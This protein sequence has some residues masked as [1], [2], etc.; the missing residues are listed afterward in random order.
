M[1]LATAELPFHGTSTAAVL[2]SILRDTPEPPVRVNSEL[3]SELGRIIGKSL[4]KDRDLRYQNAAELRGDLKRLKRDTDSN[5]PVK[6]AGT[7]SLRQVAGQGGR[8]RLYF[9]LG[10]ASVILGFAMAAF[11]FIRPLPPVRVLGT[12]QLTDDRRPKL[13]PFLTDGS[14]VYFNTGNA[15]DLQTQQVSARGGESIPFPIPLKHAR[16]LDISRDGS[17]LLVGSYEQVSKATSLTLWIA[18]VIGGSPRRLGDIVAEDAGLSADDQQVVYVKEKERE[19]DIARNDGTG[20][21]KL[22]T[23]PGIPSFPRWSPDGKR[24]RFT[25]TSDTSRGIWE[26]SADGSYL[27]ALLPDWREAQCCGNWTQD[28]KYFVFEATS[29]GVETVWA[30]REKVGFFRTSRHEPM[31]LTPGPMNTISPVPSPDGNRLF[32]DGYQPRSELVRYDSKSKVFAPF[33]RGA[34]IQGLDFSRDGK[35]VTYVSYPESTLWRSAVDGEQRVQLTASPMQVGLP[36]WSPDGKRIAFMA[37]Y[38]GTEWRISM[39]SADGG[40]PEQLTTGEKATGYD[41]TWSPD[42]NALVFGGNPQGGAQPARNLALHV[43]HLATR[44]LATVPGS[45][46]LWAPR[47]SPDGRYLSA[48][49]TD[50]ESL[51]LFDFQTQKWTELLRASIGYPSWSRDSRYVYFESVGLNAAFFRV[52]IKDGKVERVVD[53]K[54]LP[55]AVGSLGVWAGL[56]ADGS[57]LFQRDASLDE[58]YAID[59]EAR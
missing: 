34:S 5:S 36:R 6:A 16:L 22:V 59:W 56:A 10:A 1:K 15:V 14:R 20:V 35:W 58:I 19:L 57:P 47:W 31:Q 43:L 37:R 40:A 48:L 23:V 8:R 30:I 9:L 50:A 44:Q 54:D 49:S 46:G 4:E 52:R 27:H 11:L 39:L 2:A 24:I 41:P 29:K 17:E 28:G 3:P 21:R 7:D 13:R 42:G 33:L 12:T 45:E 32:V 51:L 53:L 25:V 55:R 26:V 18:P 38:P